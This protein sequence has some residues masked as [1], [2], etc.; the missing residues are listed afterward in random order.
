M[1]EDNKLRQEFDKLSE[2]SSL[3]DFQRYIETMKRAGRSLEAISVGPDVMGGHTPRECFR[4]SSIQPF[5]SD[6]AAVLAE[7]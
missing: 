6:L 7:L 2:Q 1:N 4:I 3:P 5:W